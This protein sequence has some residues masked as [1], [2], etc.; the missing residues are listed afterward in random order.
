MK[1]WSLL[2]TL[3]SIFL[4]NQPANAYEHH[5]RGWRDAR[6][7]V[8]VDPFW[9]PFA[10]A[11]IFYP[12]PLVYSYPSRPVIVRDPG[13]PEY[14]EQNT[15]PA[16]NGAPHTYWYYCASFEKYYPDV[17]QCPTTWIKVPARNP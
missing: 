10:V 12:P 9:V 2:L 16:P 11:P 13:P 3:L 8:W 14:I 17:A 1:K 7:N 6:V 4:I 15:S 5:H